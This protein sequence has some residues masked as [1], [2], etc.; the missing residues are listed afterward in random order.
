MFELTA[1]FFAHKASVSIGMFDVVEFLSLLAPLVSSGHR[2]I[3]F[4]FFLYL[5]EFMN[6]Y[7]LNFFIVRIIYQHSILQ[8]SS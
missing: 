8:V 1:D 6:F 3:L 5:L 2:N 4:L 7:E